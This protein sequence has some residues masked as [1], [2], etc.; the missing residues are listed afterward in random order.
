M[1][2]KVKELGLKLV[3][4]DFKHCDLY[5]VVSLFYCPQSISNK[6]ANQPDKPITK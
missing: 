3:L 6:P 1:A 2:N 4:S 5:H